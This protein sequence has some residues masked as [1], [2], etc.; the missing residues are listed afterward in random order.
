MMRPR[1]ENIAKTFYRAPEDRKVDNYKL[2]IMK[3]TRLDDP[4]LEV[5]IHYSNFIWTR[6]K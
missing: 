3:V 1:R 5:V 4:R 2:V 6:A